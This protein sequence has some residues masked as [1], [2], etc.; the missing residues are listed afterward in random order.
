MQALRTAATAAGLLPYFLVAPL[1]AQIDYRNLDDDR[2][3]MDEW[4]MM[5]DH[6]G[7][8]DLM[9]GPATGLLNPGP[10]DTAVNHHH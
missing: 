3:S 2:P 7:G 6:M 9:G 10:A 4:R 5:A 8:V 1:S